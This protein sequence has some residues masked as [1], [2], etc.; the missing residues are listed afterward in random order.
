MKSLQ[1]I[2]EEKGEYLT[3]VKDVRGECD[4]FIDLPDDVEVS[5]QTGNNFNLH[6][7]KIK[8]HVPSTKRF[9]IFQFKNPKSKRYIKILKCD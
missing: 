7:V 9:R 5:V 3:L 4:A 2:E 8:K 1:D 6:S